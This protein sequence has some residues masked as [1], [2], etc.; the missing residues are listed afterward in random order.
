[1]KFV[2]PIKDPQKIIAL[3]NLLKTRK[4]RDYMLFMMGIHSGLRISDLLSLKV[5]DVLNQH[6]ITIRE[7]KTGKTKSFPL[8]SIIKDDLTLYLSGRTTGWLFPSRQNGGEPITRQMAYYFLSKAA[9]D[10]GISDPIGTHTLRKTF[11]YWAY[12]RG[13]SLE[14]IQKILNHASPSVTLRYIGITQEQIDDVYE[15]LRFK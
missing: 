14:L 7:Q 12:K 5:E 1:M 3:K 2:Y 13:T 9:K 10:V 15:K 11:A 6:R 8:A 4:G